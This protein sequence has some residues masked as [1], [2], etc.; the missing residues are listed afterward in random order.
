M[1]TQIERLARVEEKVDT[2]AT[3]V[4]GLNEKF[5]GLIEKLD[6]R[7]TAKWIGDA[8]KVGFGLIL[9]AVLGLF[10]LDPLKRWAAPVQTVTITT[11]NPDGTTTSKS[12]P[13]GSSYIIT[14]SAKPSSTTSQS[15]PQ[16]QAQDTTQK[17]DGV[18]GAAKKALGL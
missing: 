14:P 15:A 16:A 10:V 18:L 8:V 9:I 7:Y 6:G 2:V 1:P 3:K 11:Q 5:D 4:D 17:Q 13:A 12:V